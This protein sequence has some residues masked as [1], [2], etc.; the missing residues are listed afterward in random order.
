MENIAPDAR[1]AVNTVL[2]K[3]CKSK[4][5]DVQLKEIKAELQ[6]LKQSRKCN[7]E[8]LEGMTL[9]VGISKDD[10][11][12]QDVQRTIDHQNQLIN[13]LNQIKEDLEP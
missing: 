7:Q 8:V 2:C 1:M 6:R 13:C 10:K 9:V 3:C 11:F 4:P 5:K 12:V